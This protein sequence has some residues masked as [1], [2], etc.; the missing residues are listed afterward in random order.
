[1]QEVE[2]CFSGVGHRRVSV[3]R[4]LPSHVSDR[5]ALLFLL[6]Q[7]IEG[8]RTRRL[9]LSSKEPGN[10]KGK[11]DEISLSNNIPDSITVFY[12]PFLIA[13]TSAPSERRREQAN[14]RDEKKAP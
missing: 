14:E 10:W 11:D 7:I 5:F 13:F 1:M 9:S 6:N 4:L 12:L 8:H 3:L 2:R